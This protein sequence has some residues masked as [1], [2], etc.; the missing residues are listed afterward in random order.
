[1]L[2]KVPA[3][4]RA[5]M[6]PKWS[7]SLHPT[8]RRGL[9][10]ARA[11]DNCDNYA[12]P[13]LL[14]WFFSSLPQKPLGQLRQ[15]GPVQNQPRFRPAPRS[16]ATESYSVSLQAQESQRAAVLAKGG[17]SQVEANHESRYHGQRRSLESMNDHH[18]NA[19]RAHQKPIPPPTILLGSSC[20]D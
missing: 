4:A 5:A 16:R 8:P 6:N 3:S 2:F 18:R 1:V 9:Y 19:N 17:N 15:R 13:F 10:D 14:R 12:N 7:L 20:G 11:R